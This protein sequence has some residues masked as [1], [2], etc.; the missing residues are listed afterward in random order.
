M[1]LI[2]PGSNFDFVGRRQGF[3]IASVIVNLISIIL[4]TTWGLNYGLDFTGGA[5]VEVRFLEP[6]TSTTVREAIAKA[7]L[8]D[9]TIQEIST[10]GTMF[11]LRTVHT[12]EEYDRAP[13]ATVRT[14]QEGEEEGVPTDVGLEPLH[15]TEN[16]RR[17]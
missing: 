4:L 12:E 8:T 15:G 16:G 13:E 2:P 6:T 7:G 14:D 17:L 5:M 3:V 11:L 10:G 1:E 9:V